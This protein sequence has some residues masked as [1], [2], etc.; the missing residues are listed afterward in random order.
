M[1]AESLDLDLSLACVAL[2]MNRVRD[3]SREI[4]GYLRLDS[5]LIMLVTRRDLKKNDIH[6][7]SVELH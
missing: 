1:R 5:Y 2:C 6:L 4:S 7:L 3:I